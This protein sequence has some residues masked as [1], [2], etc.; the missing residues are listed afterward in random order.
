MSNLSLS[1]MKFLH[2]LIGTPNTPMYLKFTGLHTVLDIWP[3]LTT[4]SSAMQNTDLVIHS[5]YRNC[6]L[7]TWS[8]LL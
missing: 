8:D 2:L 5:N 7:Q 6:I 4:I 1:K 3:Y